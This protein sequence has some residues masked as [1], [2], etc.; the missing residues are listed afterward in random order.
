MLTTSDITFVDDIR[1]YMFNLR[2]LLSSRTIPYIAFNERAYSYS[3]AQ[4][5]L[6]NMIYRSATT[7][8]ASSIKVNYDL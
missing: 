5:N 4:S 7:Q 1:I 3:C 6:L 8:C 2:L